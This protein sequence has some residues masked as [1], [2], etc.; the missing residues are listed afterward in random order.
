MEKKCKATQNYIVE[1]RRELHKIPELGVHIPKTQEFICKELDKMGVSYK[2]NTAVTKDGILDCGIIALIEGKNLDKVLAIR[3][4]MDAL[5]I[6]EAPGAD[7]CSLHSGVMHAC[8]HD[9]HMAILLGT[10]KVLQENK[11]MLNGSVKILFQT[12][13][14]I[15]SGAKLLIAGGCMENPKVTACIGTHVWPSEDAKSGT[16]VVVAGPV[17][18]SGNRFVIR[19]KGKGCHGSMPQLGIDPVA[20]LAQ[21][22][23]A[24]QNISSREI[25]VD[26][27]NVLSICQVHSGT[28]WNI[29]PEDAFMEG[30]IRTLNPKT[31]EYCIKR[32]DEIVAGVCQAMRCEGGVEWVDGT[33]V[34]MNDVNMTHIVATAAKK[35]LGEEYVSQSVKPTMGNEDF[36][37]YQEIVPSTFMFLNISNTE[38]MPFVALHNPK[39]NLDEDVLWKGTAVQVQTALDYLK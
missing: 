23:S 33:P 28:S 4:D 13:E 35:I 19:V 37:Y 24:L 14:E 18:A 39:F 3:A 25:S 7:Y 31:R 15:L 17:M 11:D 27:P 20:A 26:E 22:I 36:A 1:M 38:K 30:T 21:I 6:T 10:T 34:V 5:P 32:V 9:A 16:A 12:S 2:K 29:V 8:G